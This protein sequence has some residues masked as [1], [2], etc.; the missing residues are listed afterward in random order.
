[1]E[2][3]KKE[4]MRK[5]KTITVES[6]RKDPNHA[7]IVV[8]ASNDEQAKKIKKQIIKALVGIRKDNKRIGLNF[9]WKYVITTDQNKQIYLRDD[10]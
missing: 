9:S 6:K 10:S 2:E 4:S 5:V 8:K 1:M 3:G 7:V